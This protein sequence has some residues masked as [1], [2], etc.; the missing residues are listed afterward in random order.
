MT[1]EE[2]EKIALWMGWA[3]C[4]DHHGFYWGKGANGDWHAEIEEVSL[5]GFEVEVLSRIVEKGYYYDLLSG[6]DVKAQLAK[7]GLDIGHSDIRNYDYEDLMD[8]PNCFRSF[9]LTIH[10]AME[11]ALLK[12]ILHEEAK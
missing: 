9:E 4:Q 5:C 10:E 3:K 12:L 11:H 2:F 6:R 8:D 1:A 7:V